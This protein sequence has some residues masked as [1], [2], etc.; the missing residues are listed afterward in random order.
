MSS[1]SMIIGETCYICEGIKTFV[2][3]VWC[4]S[5]PVSIWLS[6]AYYQ[7]FNKIYLRMYI[8]VILGVKCHT[9]YTRG[10]WSNFT[11]SANG[12][13]RRIDFFK[14]KW[15]VTYLSEKPGEN[16]FCNTNHLKISA[17]SEKSYIEV[18]TYNHPCRHFPESRTFKTATFHRKNA[19]P[20]YLLTYLE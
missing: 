14:R 18:I 19:R 12:H 1:Y 15:L 13:F 7:N 3:L 16:D 6:P 5:R 2:F 4:P 9:F 8:F 10:F 20:F 11:I 17:H